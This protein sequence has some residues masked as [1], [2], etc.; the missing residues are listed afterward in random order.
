MSRKSREVE[1]FVGALEHQL[2]VKRIRRWNWADIVLKG[3]SFFVRSK[4]HAYDTPFI[5]DDDDLI[6]LVNKYKPLAEKLKIKED[7]DRLTQLE[8]DK[9]VLE[10]RIKRIKETCK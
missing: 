6:Y 9:L 1:D 5:L 7:C 3:K 2:S 8:N 4:G 10:E